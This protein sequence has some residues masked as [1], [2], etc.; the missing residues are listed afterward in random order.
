MKSRSI[1][2]ANVEDQVLSLVKAAKAVLDTEGAK[3]LYHRLKPQFSEKNIKMGRDKFLKLLKVNDLLQKKKKF[4]PPKTDSDHPFRKHKNLIKELIVN[5]PDQVYVSDITYIR[6][7]GEWNYLT[8]IMDLFSRKIM[9]YQ[10]STGMKVNQ[11]TLPAIKMAIKNRQNDQLTILHSDRGFQ[12]CNPSFVKA[13]AKFNIIPSMTNNGDPY[14]NAHAERLNGILKYEFHLK[15]HFPD[16]NTAKK[17]IDNA[18]KIYNEHRLHWSLGLATP[19]FVY[20]N[21]QLFNN[22]QTK[23]Y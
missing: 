8:L 9:G 12:Y 7:N 19:N 6:V 20:D 10:F 16:F 5:M 13:N 14:E 22:L 17:E 11:T 21:P 2:K 1:L 23:S 15:E 3:K 4:K 18:I